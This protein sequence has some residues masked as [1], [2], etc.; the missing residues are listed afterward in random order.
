M[1]Y[2]VLVAMAL[3]FGFAFEQFYGSELKRSPGGVRA[4]PLL[5]FLGA[6]L[7]LAEPRY[8]LAFIAGLLVLGGWLVLDVR[9]RTREEDPGHGYLVVPVCVLLAYALGAVALTQPTWFTV[10]LTVVA[11]LLIGSRARL[12]LIAQRVPE[13]E[14]LT[15]GQFLLL[16]GVVLPLLYN[17]PVIPFTTITPFKVWLGVVS[18]SAISYASY[19]IDRYVMHDRGTVVAA[20]LGGLYSSTA[21]TIVIARHAATAGYGRE[22]S[23]G[24]ILATAMMYVRMLVLVAL[25]NLALARELLIPV[26]I[27]IAFTCVLAAIAWRITPPVPP[28]HEP[29]ENPLA[30]GTAL[31]FAL[32]LIVFSQ[33]STWATA[34]MGNRGLLELAAV[35]GFTEVDPFVV[36]IAQNPALQIAVAAGAILIATSSNDVL[37]AIFAAAISRRRDSRIPVAALCAIAVLGLLAAWIVLR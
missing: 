34:H 28:V 30:L 29:R 2:I 10:A 15:L 6:A 24:T 14:V 19:L 12:H 7:Y 1:Q 16:V 20:V 13:R 22:R 4:F 5:S 33:L 32:L 27:L 37:K 18:V 26:I 35:I 31:L 8:L 36:S 11:V 21:T 3:F 17:A 23:S 9:E 25:F